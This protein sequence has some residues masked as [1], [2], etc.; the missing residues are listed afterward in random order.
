VSAIRDFFAVSFGVGL[1]FNALLQLVALGLSF[2]LGLVASAPYGDIG[3]GYAKLAISLAVVPFAIV[4]SF[5]ATLL[6]VQ[7]LR[8][9][10]AVVAGAAVTALLPVGLEYVL[11][12][13][14][15]SGARAIVASAA[16]G[17]A[18]ARGDGGRKIPH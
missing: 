4:A 3:P 14:V 18:G 1:G 2:V 16:A 8:S 7:H 10:V 5:L 17:L 13:E 12:G 11:K 6:L 9:F 15:S